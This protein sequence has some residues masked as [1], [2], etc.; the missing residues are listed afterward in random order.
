MIGIDSYI[1]TKA[2]DGE[3]IIFPVLEAECKYIYSINLGTSLI[4]KTK[5]D[6]PKASKLV[7]HHVVVDEKTNKEYAKAK[8]AVG[9]YYFEKGLVLSFGKEINK[10]LEDYFVR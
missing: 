4:V 8:T 5:L 10:M 1:K 3:E 9:V 2:Q 7:F 6:K